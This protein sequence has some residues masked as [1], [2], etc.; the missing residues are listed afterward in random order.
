[1]QDGKDITAVDMDK[2]LTL[3]FSFENKYGR[4]IQR[5]R[6]SI[7]VYSY[8]DSGDGCSWEEQPTGPRL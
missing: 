7:S 8:I 1:M 4:P 5:N 3:V 2:P 6:F